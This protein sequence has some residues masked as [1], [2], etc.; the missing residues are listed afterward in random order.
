M[1]LKC[2]LASDYNVFQ[3]TES[4]NWICFS[5]HRHAGII[6]VYLAGYISCC[7]LFGKGGTA[8]RRL[9]LSTRSKKAP[10]S[11]LMAN[12]G[13]SRHVFTVSVLRIPH[14]AQRHA[15]Q[16]NWP[17]GVN[18]NVSLNGCSFPFSPFNWLVTCPGY[19]L[20]LIWSQKTD[21]SFVES[22]LKSM[23]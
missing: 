8:V 7:K 15:D 6:F 18:V 2:T 17:K 11:N 20:P 1:A 14:T 13:L 12:W 21:L 23:A 19:I 9:A 5:P 4:R 16:V 22:V 10:G 3:M